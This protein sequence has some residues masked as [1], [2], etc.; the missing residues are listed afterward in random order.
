MPDQVV[1]LFRRDSAGEPDLFDAVIDLDSAGGQEPNALWRVEKDG[2][3]CY[4]RVSLWMPRKDGVFSLI[5]VYVRSDLSD[6]IQPPELM[7]LIMNTFDSS[8]D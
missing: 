7:D 4:N 5:T 6:A 3:V 1:L 2:W 8:E